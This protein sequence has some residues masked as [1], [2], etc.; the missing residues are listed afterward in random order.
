MR[1]G[2]ENTTQ[3]V[4]KRSQRLYAKKEIRSHPHHKLVKEEMENFEKDNNKDNEWFNLP[5]TEQE[6]L[7][8]ITNKKNHK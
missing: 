3:R 6:I 5:P 2:N 4:S 8:V 1:R 7:E